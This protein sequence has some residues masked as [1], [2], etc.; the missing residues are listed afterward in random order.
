MPDQIINNLPNQDIASASRITPTTWAL[1]V[2]VVLALGGWGWSTKAN[3]DTNKEQA[4]QLKEIEKTKADKDYLKEQIDRVVGSLDELKQD[5]KDLRDQRYRV[6][7]TVTNRSDGD[8][9]QRGL[10]Q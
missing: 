9:R 6:Q 8:C 1:I 5:V 10:N 2:T 7:P 3:S 4:A